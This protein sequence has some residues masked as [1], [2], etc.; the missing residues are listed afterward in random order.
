[1][2]V[3]IST[4]FISSS[5]QNTC[6]LFGLKTRQHNVTGTG[7]LL[8]LQS[9]PRG[10]PDYKINDGRVPTAT[11]YKFMCSNKAWTVRAAIW[12]TITNFKSALKLS[13][14]YICIYRAYQNHWSGFNLPSRLWKRLQKLSFPHGTKQQVFK[15]S[16]HAQ[17]D[18]PLLSRSVT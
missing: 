16:A 4:V 14:N 13:Q 10:R 11:S 17:S 15:F 1:M 9:G 12:K 3:N 18:S 5:S 8:T 6:T 7:F 2:F